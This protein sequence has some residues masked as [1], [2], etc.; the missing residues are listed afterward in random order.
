MDQVTGRGHLGPG[1]SVIQVTAGVGRRGV[2][3]QGLKR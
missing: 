2:K 1:L 3:L